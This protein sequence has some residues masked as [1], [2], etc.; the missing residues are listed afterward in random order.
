[1]NVDCHTCVGGGSH[2]RRHADKW[3]VPQ[4]QKTSRT[5]P[6]NAWNPSS[7]ESAGAYDAFPTGCAGLSVRSTLAM[8]VRLSL[9]TNHRP[10]PEAHLKALAHRKCRRPPNLQRCSSGF[11]STVVFRTR[12][13]CFSGRS[14]RI[15]PLSLVLLTCVISTPSTE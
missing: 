9:P 10:D 6:G 15:S 2:Q 7:S 13:A 12:S 8:T 3:E 11:H 5:S 14:E 4:R 1:M